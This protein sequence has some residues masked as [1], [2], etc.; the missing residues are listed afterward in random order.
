MLFT[1][2]KGGILQTS[3]YRINSRPT[4]NNDPNIG[5][6]IGPGHGKPNPLKQWRKQL[7]P[8]YKSNSKQVT[9]NDIDQSILTDAEITHVTYNELLSTPHCVGID[10]TDGCKGGSYNIRRS[11]STIIKP[12]YCTSTKQYLQ[13]RCK[14]YEQNQT[15]GKKLNATN[16]D[17]TRCFSDCNYVTYKPNNATFQ[18]QGS[19]TAEGYTAKIKQDAVE[20]NP[21]NPS[22]KTQPECYISKN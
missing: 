12:N 3:T 21:Y 20:Q 1:Y 7:Q 16:Y 9:F 5:H 22:K 10:T 2:G 11:G 13:K 8:Y 6:F 15:I 19:A 18:I 14:T 4:T 17:S